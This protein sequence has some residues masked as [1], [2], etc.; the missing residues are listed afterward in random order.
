MRPFF[1]HALKILVCLSIIFS[2]HRT[3]AFKWLN[4]ESSFKLPIHIQW[5]GNGFLG[6]IW[7]AAIISLF[8][9][10]SSCIFWMVFSQKRLTHLYAASIVLFI[11]IITTLHQPYV[12][13]FKYQIVPSHLLGNINFDFITEHS[14]MLLSYE[15]LFLIF[16][17]GICCWWVSRRE[18]KYL[19]LATPS[20]IKPGLIW[21]SLFACSFLGHSLNHYYNIALVIPNKLQN[22]WMEIIYKDIKQYKM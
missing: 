1:Y 9:I 3:L 17:T 14:Y 12:S 16:V 15:S 20:A 10:L 21:L 6:D 22:H 18:K 13:F 11:G 4:N 7:I 19:L 8:F 5:L 2:L